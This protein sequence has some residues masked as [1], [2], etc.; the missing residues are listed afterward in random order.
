MTMV[1]ATSERPTVW[2]LQCLRDARI[3]PVDHAARDSQ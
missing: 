3:P 2:T 1:E